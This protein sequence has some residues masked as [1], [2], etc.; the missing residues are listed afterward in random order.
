MKKKNIY[1]YV[2]EEHQTKIELQSTYDKEICY[3]ILANF[4]SPLR[5]NSGF[6]SVPAKKIHRT[7]HFFP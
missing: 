1:Y 7:V 5:D 4:S 3:Q 6:V 2:L